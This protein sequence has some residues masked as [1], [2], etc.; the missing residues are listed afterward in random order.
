MVEKSQIEIVDLREVDPKA[1][2]TPGQ[3]VARQQVVGNMC[4]AAVN[5]FL[6]SLP[7]CCPSVAGYKGIQVDRD[8]NVAE[9]QS[10]C[11]P[12]EQLVAEQ[13]AVSYTHLTL[14][15]IYSV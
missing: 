10:T 13:H 14:P 8:I 4:P 7:V 15:T 9:I 3:H 2:F 6:V 5:M 1:V 12:N 11:I